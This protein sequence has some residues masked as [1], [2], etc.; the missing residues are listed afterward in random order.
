M[1]KLINDSTY[2]KLCQLKLNDINCHI[3]I[4]APNIIPL[5]WVILNFFHAIL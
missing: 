4:I 1:H 5:K 3:K 2:A